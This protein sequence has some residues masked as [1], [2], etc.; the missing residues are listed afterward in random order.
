M[1]LWM[2][3]RKGVFTLLLSAHDVKDTK[4][5]FPKVQLRRE[6]PNGHA[7]SLGAFLFQAA[8][9]FAQMCESWVLDQR[10]HSR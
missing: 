1:T 2:T 6:W 10:E 5:E 4:Q 3:T 9:S 7:V 8:N